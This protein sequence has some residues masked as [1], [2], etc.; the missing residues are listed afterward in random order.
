MTRSFLLGALLLTACPDPESI[1]PEEGARYVSTRAALPTI[2]PLD[3][4]HFGYC[5]R[6]AFNHA[7][8]SSYCAGMQEVCDRFV[9]NRAFGKQHAFDLELCLNFAAENC[10]PPYVLDQKQLIKECPEL[11]PR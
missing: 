4:D 7:R 2:K 5:M 6:R 11:K 9:A 10:A 8:A 1:N 3:T